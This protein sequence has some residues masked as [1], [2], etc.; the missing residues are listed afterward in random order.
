VFVQGAVKLAMEKEQNRVIGHNLAM[1]LPRVAV[2]SNE[3]ATK[4]RDDLRERALHLEIHRLS[5]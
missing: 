4:W 5:L 2:A 3:G 1:H